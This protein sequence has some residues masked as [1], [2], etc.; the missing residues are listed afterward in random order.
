M[1]LSKRGLAVTALL[2][3]C[4]GEI[5]AGPPVLG[6]STPA[7]SKPNAEMPGGETPG[8]VNPDTGAPAAAVATVDNGNGTVTVTKADGSMQVVD[9]QTGEVIATTPAP[10]AAADPAAPNV[11]NTP[12]PALTDP[13]DPA[14]ATPAPVAAATKCSPGTPK[15]TQI[16]RLTNRQYD[17]TVRDL[18]N[19]DMQL[20]ATTLQADSKGNMDARTWQ[21]YEDAAAAIATTII[22]DA[23]AR[24]SVIKCTT[25]DAACAAQVISDF[26]AQVFRRPLDATETARYQALFADTT[27]T[28]TGTFDEQMQVV[29]QA[30]FQSP[31]FIS[32]AEISETPSADVN[33]AQ[34]FALNDYELASRLSYLLWDT[35][36]D[37]A[38]M[39]AAAAGQLSQGTGLAERAA[40]ML[41]DPRA[42]G[43]IERMHMDYMRMGQN[44]RWV[45]YT[46]DA[47]QFPA[48]NANQIDAIAQ[49]E[50]AVAD[51]VVLGGGTFAQLMTTTVGYVN[52]DTAPLYGLNPADY[53]SELTQVDLG[54]ARPGLLT[55]AGFLA[56]NSYGNR[57]SPIHRGAFIMKDVLCTPLGDPSPN[58]AKTP[59]PEDANLIT[60]RQKT[61]AQTSIGADCKACHSTQIN[62][63]GFALEG[64]DAVGGVQTTDNGAPVDTVADVIVGSKVVHVNGAAE[65]MAAIAEAPEAK[66][67]YTEN[68]VQIA[69]NRVLSGEDVCTVDDIAQKLTDGSYTVANLITDL[70]STETFRYRALETEV[71]Q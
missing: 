17:N 40:L 23:N 58:A 34:R 22:T 67:C 25:Q 47:N 55:R 42:K 29:L 43:L 70:A 7:Q 61:D 21:S 66:R 13:A 26:G 36:P 11:A 46:R 57:T 28:E 14:A 41:Q 18:I 15:S 5:G 49:E 63:P 12:T 35:K 44:T 31:Y 52:A 10:A 16:P 8:A 53:T 60:N 38:L 19:V 48:Y 24:A 3:G 30:M 69:Y 9:Q 20:A 37:Q 50:L 65:L 68:W 64:F 27:L 2:A 6:D 59:L 71:P 56:A 4:S 39:D 45:G 32:V 62:P 54:A 51:S 33:G 1:Y